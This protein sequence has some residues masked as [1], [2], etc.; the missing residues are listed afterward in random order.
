M[1]TA[2]RA[3]RG[4]SARLVSMRVRL[5]VM[6]KAADRKICVADCGHKEGSRQKGM[7]QRVMSESYVL[8]DRK[9]HVIRQRDMCY[10]TERYV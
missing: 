7:C 2:A 10:L 6:G 5:W 3:Q 8:S 1:V 4:H 9:L